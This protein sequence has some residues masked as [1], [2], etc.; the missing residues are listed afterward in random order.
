MDREYAVAGRFY[1]ATAKAIESSLEE[2]FSKAKAT[3]LTGVRAIIAPH[4]GYIFS[5]EVAASAYNQIAKGS[6]YQRVFVLSSAHSHYFQG[7]SL[8]SAGNYLM[9]YGSVKVDTSLA[10]FFVNEYP[11]LFSNN[12]QHHRGDHTIEVQLPFIE[13]QLAKGWLLVPILFGDISQEQIKEIA[14]ALRP[15]FND[16]NLFVV[17]SDLSHYPKYQDANRVDSATIEAILSNDID[18]FLSTLKG[19]SSSE[20]ESLQT[21][22]C[23]ADALLTL[24]HLTAE[25]RLYNYKKID[26]KNSGDN[27][28]YGEKE[29][30]VG[31]GAIA[32]TYMGELL[33]Q[34]AEGVIKKAIESEEFTPSD[35]KVKRWV[36]SILQTLE[37][38]EI[39]P[40]LTYESGVFVTLYKDG[41]LRGCVGFIQSSTP[42]YLEVAN[43]AL[44]AAFGDW[45]FNRV[46]ERELPSLEYEISVLSP[47]KLIANIAEIEL[48]KHGILVKSGSKSGLFLPKVAT[49][50]GWDLEQFLGHCSRDKAGLGWSGWKDAD[51]FIFTVDIV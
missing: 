43:A 35:Q 17:S 23:G 49:D 36:D 40:S 50:T 30:V 7:A 45:R 6:S 48:G 16:N 20:V 38:E 25:N 11:T 27:A 2:L 19:H 1:P 28:K 26:Y 47:M 42:L 41:K 39:H 22:I 5:G 46:S 33:Y 29:S 37:V 12:P 15:Y 24:L 4:A 44:L 31:Y 3:Q 21:A 8:Y 9:P 32:I 14:E 10:K 34:I 13:H 18:T 51:L